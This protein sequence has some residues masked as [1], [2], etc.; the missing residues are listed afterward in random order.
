[1]NMLTACF[2]LQFPQLTFVTI[3][4]GWVQTD[5]GG[6]AGRRADISVEESVAG[7]YQVFTSLTPANSGTFLDWK[8]EELP[9]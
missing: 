2:A 9:F 5:M 6:A 1:M 3:H 4:P 7:I 8:G